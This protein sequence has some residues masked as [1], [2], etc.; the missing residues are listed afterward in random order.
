MRILIYPPFL[1]LITIEHLGASYDMR[2]RN[3]SVIRD[4]I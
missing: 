1:G 2:P 3:G 4:I